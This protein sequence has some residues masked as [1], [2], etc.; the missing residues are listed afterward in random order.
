LGK[1][2]SY[3]KVKNKFNY[4]DI[5]K[6]IDNAFEEIGY[7]LQQEY[8]NLPEEMI[9]WNHNFL[10]NFA[11]LIIQNRANKA[12]LELPGKFKRNNLTNVVI[13]CRKHGVLPYYISKVIAYKLLF[14]NSNPKAL[15]GMGKE[16]LKE[17]IKYVTDLNYEKELIQLIYQHYQ[18]IKFNNYIK[19]DRQKVKLLKYAYKLGFKYEK[20]YKGCAQCVLLAMYDVIGK[21]NSDL[22][23]AAS[24]LS[25]GMALCG[26][27]SCGGYTG[28]ILIMGSL[29]GR[30]IAYLESGDKKAQ[31]RSYEMAQKLR[32]RFIDTYGSVIC[33]DIHK[34][35]FGKAY[36]LKTKAVRIQFEEAGA[37]RDKCNSVVGTACQWIT[38]ILLEEGLI[39]TEGNKR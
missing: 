26:D 21:N 6:D 22:F 5:F 1:Q 2:R 30:R 8:G 17:V 23:Q 27:G 25:G 34:K 14:D 9:K 39:K 10:E 15:P 29:V 7:V 38:E 11:N 24:G 31:Y 12:E 4:D 19:E 28:G 35:I 3:E 37:H 18:K 36:C 20:K 32:D 16:D 33:S 13:L